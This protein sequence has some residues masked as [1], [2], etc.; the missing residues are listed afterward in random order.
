MGEPA[1]CSGVFR[2]RPLLCLFSGTCGTHQLGRKEKD[3]KNLYSSILKTSELL[4]CTAI[5]EVLSRLSQGIARDTSY[6][7][8]KTV[9]ERTYPASTAW[10]A[11]KIGLVLLWLPGIIAVKDSS[12]HLTKRLLLST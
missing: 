8:A 5:R 3:P 6:N 9:K 2:I 12:P 1:A 10:L 7:T 11:G 4:Y